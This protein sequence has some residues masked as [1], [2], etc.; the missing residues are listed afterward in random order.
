MDLRMGKVRRKNTSSDNKNPYNDEHKELHDFFLAVL[1][2]FG[3]ES[4][5]GGKK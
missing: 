3:R 5:L 2:R 1:M 4:L